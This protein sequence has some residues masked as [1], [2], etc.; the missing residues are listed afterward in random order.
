MTRA[1]LLGLLVA[2]TGLL[3]LA[4]TLG[5]PWQAGVWLDEQ[6]F[7]VGGTQLAHGT[8]VLA[9]AALVVTGRGV[10][11]RRRFA[12]YATVTLLLLATVA[13]LVRGLDLSS[14]A[15]TGLLALALLRMRQLFVVPLRTARITDLLPLA[16][17]LLALDLA[18]GLG[19]LYSHRDSIHPA[20]SFTAMVSETGARLV[21]FS[22]QLTID[23]R[24]GQWFPGS[25]TALGVLTTAILLL[26]VLAPVAA[27]SG[28]PPGSDRDLARRLVDR[29]DGDTLDPFALRRDKRLVFD[30]D[31]QAA[32]GYRYVRGIG[33]ASGDP[34]GD[35][36]A[37]AA[38][39]DA[40]LR[41]C[42][43]HGW[44][45]GIMGAR[46]ELLPMYRSLGLHALYIGDE[47]I[48]DVATFS[49]AGRRMRNAR[50]AVNRSRNA[51]L[52]TEILR[53]GDI[54]PGLRQVL[55]D[56]AARARLGQREFGFS[57]ALGDLLTD[58][59]PDCRIVVCRDRTGRPVAFQRYRP[60]RAGTALSLDVMRRLP[61]AP[62][63]AGERAIVDMIGWARAHG[64]ADLS[65]NFAAFRSALD[66]HTDRTPSQ[67]MTAWLVQRLDGAFGIQLDTLRRFNAKFLP[68]WAPRY[69]LYRGLGD[70]PAIGL[71]A[72]A[73]EGFLPLD[74]DRRNE[75][76]G[77]GA[78]DHSGLQKRP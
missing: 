8:A 16:V 69:L 41:L 44:R 39:T 57:M 49:L 4:S 17:V 53:E 58:E 78:A 34:V 26:A 27:L 68:R 22:G 65:L 46:Q 42:D 14:A 30:P 32:I 67:A 60:C 13:H 31:R 11:Q 35:P 19:G 24:F 71:A 3:T 48:V 66:P 21:G 37:F 47:A 25:L 51:G 54:E 50:Q 33:L 23:G 7:T 15:V 76:V 12:L 43:R 62:N 28:Q 77:T 72:L 74:P 52:T 73:A 45:P 6:L 10:A 59:Y 40:F 36:A 56:L 75:S 70:L 55:L 64:I 29:P 38:A 9:G 20:P 2:T 18:Y 1:R 61:Q 5:R 63:G